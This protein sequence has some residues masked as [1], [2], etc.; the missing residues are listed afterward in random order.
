MIDVFVFLHVM[1][2][3]PLSA[4]IPLAHEGFLTLCDQVEG[5]IIIH[6]FLQ[7]SY[8]QEMIYQDFPCVTHQGFHRA[9]SRITFCKNT[10]ETQS[11]P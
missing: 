2:H 1:Y 3:L 9:H 7:W 10:R 11:S 8:F 6:V 5:I 4:Q